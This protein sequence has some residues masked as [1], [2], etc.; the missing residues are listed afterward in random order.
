MNF[1]RLFG[2]LPPLV[3]KK[4]KPVTQFLLFCYETHRLNL[5]YEQTKPQAKAYA[6]KFVLFFF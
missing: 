2:A 5:C 4:Q 1:A 3:A 6:T